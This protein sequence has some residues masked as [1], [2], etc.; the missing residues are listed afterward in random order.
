MARFPFSSPLSRL[1][2][3]LLPIL[4]QPDITKPAADAN[5]YVNL[6]VMSQVR[7][8][9]SAAFLGG[10]PSISLGCRVVGLVGL[11]F[12]FFFFA[13]KYACTPCT[14]RNPSRANTPPCLIQLQDNQEV[15][16]KI[17]RKTP[18]RKLINAYIERQ[19]RFASGGPVSMTN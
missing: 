1:L 11:V 5:E 16:F 4:L 9:F 7:G 17:K 15:H 6:K 13:C 14:N 12:F 18:M 8:S 3:S 19:V 2:I 10:P